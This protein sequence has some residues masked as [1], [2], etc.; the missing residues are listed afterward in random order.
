MDEYYQC[1]RMMSLRGPRRLSTDN[2]MDGMASRQHPFVYNSL[3]Y[4]SDNHFQWTS[5]PLNA[6]KFARNLKIERRAVAGPVTP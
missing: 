1:G 4:W 2:D 6:C 3:E 5:C